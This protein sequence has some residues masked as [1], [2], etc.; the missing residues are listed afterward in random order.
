MVDF[1]FLLSGF[2]MVHVY[3]PTFSN[4][5]AWTSWKRFMQHRFARIYPLHFFSFAVMVAF[6]LIEFSDKKPEGLDAFIYN[7]YAIPT[8]LLLI[9]SL[10]IHSLFSWN[11]PSWSISTEWWMYVIFPFLFPWWQSLNKLKFGLLFLGLAAGYLFI[12]YILYPHSVASSPLP[13]NRGYSLDVTYNYGFFRCFL[14]FVL[15]MQL[16]RIYSGGWMKNWLKSDFLFFG[17]VGLAFG[18]MHFGLPDYFLVLCFAALLLMAVWNAGLAG[19]IL[20]WKPLQF[21]GDISY[22]IYMIHGPLLFIGLAIMGHLFPG[23]QYDKTPIQSLF[24][25]LA[26]LGLLLTVSY[27]TYRTIELPFR[28]WL[29]GRKPKNG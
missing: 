28:Q 17:V 19:T 11:V 23:I 27:L 13:M 2:I 16:Y 6:F 12:N 5:P 20:Q 29:G 21:L 15:G 7:L 3:G 24:Y 18:L 25:V 8:N 26:Y 1:F 10:G 4:G 9:H 14:G 22:S